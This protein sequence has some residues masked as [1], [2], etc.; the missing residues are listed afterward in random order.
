M[1]EKEWEVLPPEDQPNTTVGA[2][3]YL[4]L[5]IGFAIAGI[6]DALSIW[7]EFAPPLQWALDLGTALLLFLTLGR[8]PLLL[9][10]LITEAIPG[11][12]VFPAWLLVVGSIAL[13]GSVKK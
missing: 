2:H 11:L 6:S 4:R 8:Q 5:G 3:N 1:A 9:P 10:A 13:W 7:L 12:A